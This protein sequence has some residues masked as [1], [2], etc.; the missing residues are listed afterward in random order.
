MW[1][2]WILRGLVVG[3]PPERLFVRKQTIF[4]YFQ[5][6]GSYFVKKRFSKKRN[7]LI[8]LNQ[9]ALTKMTVGTVRS[10]HGLVEN[11]TLPLYLPVKSL[12]LCGN[13]IFMFSL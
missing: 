3:K 12:F 13:P 1:G 9:S 8:D 2:G 6:L 11:L 7:F 10:F 4:F 5:E